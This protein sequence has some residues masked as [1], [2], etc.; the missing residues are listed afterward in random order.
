MPPKWLKCIRWKNGLK[1][2]FVFFFNV[3]YYI[4]S[5]KS[6]VWLGVLQ[7]YSQIWGLFPNLLHICCRI[8][9]ILQ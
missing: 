9:S 7:G 6:K 4:D 8:K 5:L 2:D 1:I 3:V